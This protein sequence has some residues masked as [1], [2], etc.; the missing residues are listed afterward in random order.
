MFCSKCGS[1]LP[2]TGT[3]C[4]ACGAPTGAGLDAA[5]VVRRPALITLLAV[6]QFLGAVLMLPLGAVTL[7]QAAGADDPDAIVA[8]IAGGVMLVIGAVNLACGIGLWTLKPYGRVL[9]IALACIGLLGIPLGTIISALILYYMWRPGIRA[10]FAGK[11]FVE[12]TRAEL[13][14]IAQVTT[15]SQAVTI[16]IIVLVAL[17]GVAM[18]GIIAAIAVPGL[19]RARMAGN[20]S[21]AIGSMR[22]IVSAETAY[23]ATAGGGHYA[24]RLTTL[25]AA[26]P[27]F[28]EGFISPELSQDPSVKSGF[29]IRLESAGV[30]AGP[31]DCN[32]V[33]TEKDFYATAAPVAFNST[34]ARSFSTSAMGIIYE[35]R[36]EVPPS[37]DATLTGTAA[38]IR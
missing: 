34:G 32:G 21:A 38:P 26:C 11:P 35:A 17:G 19:L 23:A 2:A 29:T 36:S 30:G 5:T 10:L 14:E 8:I 22:M 15:G 3:F 6:F 18:L 25:A 27:G 20:E 9:Q 13:V 33:S 24:T 28:S 31:N 12:Y 37:A 4:T 16:V 1:E 7:V